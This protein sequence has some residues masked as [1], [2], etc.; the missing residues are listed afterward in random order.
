MA[1]VGGAPSGTTS[2]A[3]A[4][5]MAAS[6]IGQP[7]LEQAP[8]LAAEAMREVELHHAHPIP[9]LARH[10]SRIPVDQSDGVAWRASSRAAV[11][12]TGPDPRTATRMTT[13]DTIEETKRSIDDT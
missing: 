8:A 4:A 6:D 10:R 5:R 3:P 13:S 9:G 1:A 2:V 12:P 11:M 7:I